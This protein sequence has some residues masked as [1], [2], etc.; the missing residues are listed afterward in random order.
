MLL[1]GERLRLLREQAGLNQKQ[2]AETVGVDA[3]TISHLE[4]NRRGVHITHAI[5]LARFFGL[6]VDEFLFTDECKVISP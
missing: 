5:K 4:Q 3:A 6:T 1:I 2:L